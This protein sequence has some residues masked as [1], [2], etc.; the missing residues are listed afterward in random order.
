MQYRSTVPGRKGRAR[1]IKHLA[2]LVDYFVFLL[3][4][5]ARAL[6]AA[7]LLA[8]PVRP[9]RS[10]FDAAVAALALV[11]LE[12]RNVL[13]PFFGELYA[14]LVTRRT[15][16]IQHIALNIK[17]NSTF[18]ARKEQKDEFYEANKS[19]IHPIIHSDATEFD[20]VGDS[21]VVE[22]SG[23]TPQKAISKRREVHMPREKETFRLELEE[24]LKFTG[25]R[26]VLTVT[27]VSNYTGQ[28]RRVCRERYNVSGKE[29]ISAVALAQML[30][31]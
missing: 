29:G 18:S 5:C 13:P 9:S 4:R 6:A 1:R 20:H 15:L 11:C 26:R 10:T 16:N 17:R 21:G 3:G 8:L 14:V 25:G 19:W 22:T 7:V 23:M 27:D 28:S 30:A 24:I 2:Q 31:R 12:L